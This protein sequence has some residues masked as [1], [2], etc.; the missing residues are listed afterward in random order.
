MMA[1]LFRLPQWSQIKRY[2]ARQRVES[3]VVPG[4]SREFEHALLPPFPSRRVP[5]SVQRAADAAAPLRHISPTPL[6]RA[7]TAPPSRP[8]PPPPRAASLP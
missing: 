5:S 4:V 8:P 1:T 7:T 3:P 2:R 6:R